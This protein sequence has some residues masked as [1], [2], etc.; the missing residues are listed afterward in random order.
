M[1]PT[2]MRPIQI[3]LVEDSPTDAELTRTALKTAKMAN[4]VIHMQDG[5]QAMQFLRRQGAYSQAAQPD[6]ILLDLNLP[7]KDGREILAELK[8]DPDLKVIPVVVLTTSKA[9]EDVI[10]SYQLHA[11]CY[12]TKP[13]NFERF[14]EIVQSIESFWLTVV[15]LPARR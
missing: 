10:R 15:S 1:T 6:L 7:R 3:L 4:E 11:N 12:V 5:V 2:T 13:V 14:L 9:E 8:E